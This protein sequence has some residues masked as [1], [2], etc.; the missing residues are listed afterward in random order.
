MINFVKTEDIISRIENF[1][2][3][4]NLTINND[5]ISELIELFNL[6]LNVEKFKDLYYHTQNCDDDFKCGLK[7]ELIYFSISNIELY[8]DYEWMS[9]FLSQMNTTIQDHNHYDKDSIVDILSKFGK[10]HKIINP[11]MKVIPSIGTCI[12]KWIFFRICENSIIENKN[13]L[14]E[15]YDYLCSFSE[16]EDFYLIRRCI[17]M[18]EVEV[19]MEKLKGSNYIRET[20]MKI[21]SEYPHLS[22]LFR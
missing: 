13:V 17:P 2:L 12:G 7:L 6:N 11:R 8:V 18:V 20:K 4:D 14:F 19:K 5:Q 10:M 16:S 15:I 1:S 21:I 9:K 22:Y 3:S